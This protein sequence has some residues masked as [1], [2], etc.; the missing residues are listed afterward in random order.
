MNFKINGSTL[1][2]SL[3]SLG[4]MMPAMGPT[5]PRAVPRLRLAGA[6]RWTR[7]TACA[8]GTALASGV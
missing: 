1:P 2:T 5:F 6:K 4:A 7:W 3:G 8:R